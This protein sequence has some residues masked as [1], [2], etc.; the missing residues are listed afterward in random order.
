MQN[1][2]L[3][4]NDYSRSRNGLI[5]RQGDNMEHLQQLLTDLE[6]ISLADI[7]ALSQEHQHVVAERLEQLE[8]AL[9][10]AFDNSNAH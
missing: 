7:S 4:C 3:V 1:T 6:C 8:E 9:K 2:F 10:A 5:Q